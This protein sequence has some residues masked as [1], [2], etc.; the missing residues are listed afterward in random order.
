[1]VSVQDKHHSDKKNRNQCVF[2]SGD[3]YTDECH[4]Y[5]TV[6]ARKQQVGNRCYI[7]L[8][9]SHLAKSCHVKYRCWHCNKF[10][11][12]HRALCPSKHSESG[13]EGRQRS[14][15]IFSSPSVPAPMDKRQTDMDKSKDVV[16]AISSCAVN[17][18]VFM[19]TTV[20]HVKG[21]NDN[22]TIKIRAILD[23]ASSHSYVSE[24]LQKLL[25]LETSKSVPMNVYTFGALEPK[26]M[27][28]PEVSLEIVTS[29]PD[30]S[31]KLFVVP[32]IVSGDNK[33]TYDLEF[34]KGLH[35]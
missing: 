10:R 25:G 1:M 24:K 27:K 30:Y 33:R 13:D 23:T 8:G 32:N 34:L 6:E 17:I 18:V 14:R 2:C 5:V 19:Q 16:S 26:R 4:K 7:C 15:N 31:L 28:A 3:H 21:K 11:H 20:L 29:I 12:H 22:E 35:Y 9:S